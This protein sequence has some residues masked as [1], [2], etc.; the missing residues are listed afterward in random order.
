MVDSCVWVYVHVYKGLTAYLC[1]WRRDSGWQGRAEPDRRS[2][3]TNPN[4][5]LL[6][7]ACFSQPAAPLLPPPRLKAIRRL[8]PSSP[9]ASFAITTCKHRLKQLFQ[10]SIHL[11]RFFW[12]PPFS[13]KSQW[14][15]KRKSQGL[16]SV[17]TRNRQIN[18]RKITDPFGFKKKTRQS[19]FLW[20][21]S[22]SKNEVNG[23]LFS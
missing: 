1:A 17:Y 18:E 15:W 20:T 13:L 2:P 11:K 6:L 8:F 5:Q 12:F 7:Q 9:E 19:L 21:F 14:A 23:S 22:K 10:K 3:T 16:Q 4:F